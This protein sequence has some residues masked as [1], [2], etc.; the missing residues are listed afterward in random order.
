MNPMGYILCD[1]LQEL[2]KI[3][4][5]ISLYFIQTSLL[6]LKTVWLSSCGVKSDFN[7][8]VAHFLCSDVCNF[9][10]GTQGVS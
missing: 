8:F 9:K 6:C 3:M 1:A 4:V 10:S 5:F 2:G 7:T